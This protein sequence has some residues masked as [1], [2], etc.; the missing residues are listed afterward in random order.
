MSRFFTDTLRPKTEYVI[1]HWI[2][3]LSVHSARGRSRTI[4]VNIGCGLVLGAGGKLFGKTANRIRFLWTP[5]SVTCTV[6]RRLQLSQTYVMPCMPVRCIY[7][8]VPFGSLWASV[9]FFRD[10]FFYILNKARIKRLFS[11]YFITYTSSY[12]CKHGFA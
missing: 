9:E 7:V 2:H 12:I 6:L 1:C 5:S 3:L 8:I 4:W 11:I 10:Y